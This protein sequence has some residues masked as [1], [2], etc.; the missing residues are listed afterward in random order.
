MDT[1]DLSGLYVL[2]GCLLLAMGIAVVFAQLRLF[3]IDRTL[4]A[5]LVELRG[6]EEAS[7]KIEARARAHAILARTRPT[8]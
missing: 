2:I 4:K 8:A 5:I 3:S 6:G 1:G 7:E